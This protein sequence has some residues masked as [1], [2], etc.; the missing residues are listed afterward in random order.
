MANFLAPPESTDRNSLVML[1]LFTLGNLA[2]ES[3]SVLSKRCLYDT[4]LLDE[5]VK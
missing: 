3:I 4:A 5:L 1:R 2:E